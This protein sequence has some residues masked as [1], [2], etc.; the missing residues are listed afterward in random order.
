VKEWSD[1]S[2]ENLTSS[3]SAQPEMDA[4]VKRHKFSPDGLDWEAQNT[5]SEE[6][7]VIPSKRRH[8]GREFDS[9]HLHHK[10]I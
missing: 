2:G 3:S 10:E 5:S 1:P 9:P 4:P 6:I 8:V 7:V